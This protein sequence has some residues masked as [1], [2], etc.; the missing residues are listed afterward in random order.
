[1]HTCSKIALGHGMK[2]VEFTILYLKNEAIDMQG[3]IQAGLSI[4]SSSGGHITSIRAL[5]T[6]LQN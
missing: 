4:T 6:T 3:L 2:I 1:M 5:Y